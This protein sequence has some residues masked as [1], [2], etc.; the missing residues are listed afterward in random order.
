MSRSR[1]RTRSRSTPLPSA[2]LPRRS[3]LAQ[4]VRPATVLTVIDEPA[5]TSV[6]RR[7]GS[8]IRADLPGADHERAG[9]VRAASRHQ[10]TRLLAADPP[11]R[12]P[13]KPTLWTVITTGIVRPRPRKSPGSVRT[14]CPPSSRR[15]P[16]TARGSNPRMASVVS[17]P[18]F[19]C[20]VRHQACGRC[21]PSSGR[22]KN[23]C[24]ISPPRVM[25]S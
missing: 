23:T 10:F 9:P 1:R 17:R 22:H 5:P 7:A 13:H 12:S 3:C 18:I 25:F 16:R 6:A 20:L 24:G 19:S 15:A 21:P 14:P 11:P 2:P 8:P 4:A